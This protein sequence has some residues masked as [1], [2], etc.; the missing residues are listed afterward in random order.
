[1]TGICVTYNTKELFQRAYESIRRFHPH[2]HMIIVD[3][4]DVDNPC[5]GYVK[6]LASPLN[7]IYQ[8]GCNI[9]HGNGMHHALER[10]DTETALVF[11]SDIVML[12]SPLSEMLGLLSSE[13][14]G[15]GWVYE[16]GYDGFDYGTYPHHV[17]KGGVPYLHPYFM[18]LNKAQYFKFHRFIHH[19]APCYKAM[20]EIYER[21]LSAKLLRNFS[22][23]TGHTSGQ[24]INWIG[25]PSKYVQHDF[26]GTR[27]TNKLA[28]KKEIIGKWD[29]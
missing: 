19:G 26:G 16:V 25:R 22:G 8:V 6:S 9:G 27:T 7:K 1:M 29:R 23:L 5:H 20:I 2:L 14:Y 28:G 12:R 24:G 11:D 18:L 21:G 17:Q 3:G 15:V 10:C 13:T 4:S